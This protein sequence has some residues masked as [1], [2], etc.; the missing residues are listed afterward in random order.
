VDDRLAAKNAGWRERR[1]ARKTGPIK[2][3]PR[4]TLAAR[5]P[6]VA[7]RGARQRHRGNPEHRAAEEADD[8]ALQTLVCHLVDP[9]SSWNCEL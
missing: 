2:I 7:V 9:F 6:S 4:P 8:I 5:M 3:S 1:I